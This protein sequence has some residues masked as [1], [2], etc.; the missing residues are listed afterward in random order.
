[1]GLGSLLLHSHRPCRYV[2]FPGYIFFTN[3][4]FF[5]LCNSVGLMLLMRRDFPELAE[6]IIIS[7]VFVFMWFVGLCFASLRKQYVTLFF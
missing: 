1:M 7:V 6:R 3:L 2:G 4:I 5:F